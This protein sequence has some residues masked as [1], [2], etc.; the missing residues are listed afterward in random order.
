MCAE[1]AVAYPS[2][3]SPKTLAMLPRYVPT[4]ILVRERSC[5]QETDDVTMSE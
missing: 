2:P 3:Y 4:L 1:V 5:V